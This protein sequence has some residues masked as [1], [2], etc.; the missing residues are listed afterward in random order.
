MLQKKKVRSEWLSLS[1]WLRTIGILVVVFAITY[2]VTRSFESAF[3]L[4]AI[5]SLV[6]LVGLWYT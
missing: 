2:A 6:G 4:T 3:I 5:Y 1:M